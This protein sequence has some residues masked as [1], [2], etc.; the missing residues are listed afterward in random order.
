MAQ[1]RRESKEAQKWKSDAIRKVNRKKLA[2]LAEQKMP[3]YA[4]G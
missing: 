4:A 1:K 3:C 2:W